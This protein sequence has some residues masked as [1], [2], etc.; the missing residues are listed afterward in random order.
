M[1]KVTMIGAGSGF[2]PQIM[3]DI[4]LVS[5]IDKGEIRLCDIDAKRLKI[6]KGLIEALSQH[7]T[8]GRWTVK[9]S[10]DRKDL[11]RGSDYV[12]NS[13]EVSGLETVRFDNDIPLKCGI[14]QCIGDTIGPGGIMKALRTV[15]P[16]LAILKDVEKYCPNALVPNYTNPMSIMTLA[17]VRSTSLQ[18]VGLC[19]S[20]QGTSH[21]LARVAGVPYEEMMYKCG[22]V[23]HF[24]FFT[25]LK[26]KGR[27]LY[28]T[29]FKR[30]RED[31]DVYEGDP[32]R[33]E[34]MFQFGYFVTESSGHFSEYLPY[35]RKRPDLVK[36]YCREGYRGGSSF[37]ADNWPKWRAGA[38]THR[39]ELAQDITEMD[40]SRSVEYGADIIEAS[41][42]NK[43]KVIYGSVLNEGLIENLPAD[44]VVEV[45]T[46][47]DGSGYNPCRFGALP[48]QLAALCR[49]NMGVY[50]CTVD[51][52]LHEDREQVVR[53]MMLDPLTSAVLAPAEIRAMTDELCL[54]EKKFIPSFMTDGVKMPARGAKILKIGK[55]KSA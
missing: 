3:K 8:K 42:L 44:G 21:G 31:K 15:P 52:L 41:Y 46:L 40:L 18:I 25:E 34:M 13:I 51:G 6:T 49:S 20:V 54:A 32:V 19:H 9:A 10:T 36:K 23:N 47:V 2:T 5:E 33:W 16:W 24:A 28:P 55:P 53:G 12:I 38:D 37:Y 27:D 14:D 45:K 35:F 30:A 1:L 39:L 17:A 29:L 26:H 43:P 48:P 7:L 11:L 50:D 4:M 22:G